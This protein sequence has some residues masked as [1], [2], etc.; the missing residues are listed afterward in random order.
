MGEV[1]RQSQGVRDSLGGGES[2][3]KP[4]KS[5]CRERECWEAELDGVLESKIKDSLWHLAS[6]CI[7]V[8]RWLS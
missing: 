6:V 1:I 2:L 3:H 5:I 7:L 4:L 8:K